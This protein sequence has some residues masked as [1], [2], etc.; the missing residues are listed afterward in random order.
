LLESIKACRQGYAEVQHIPNTGF[1]QGDGEIRKPVVAGSFYSGSAK[2]LRQQIEMCFKHPLGPGAPPAVP[3]AG[4]RQVRGLVSPHAGYIYS[5]PVASHGFFQLASDGKPEVV[6]ILGPNHRGVGAAAALSKESSWQTPLGAV[7][8]DSAAGNQ[9]IAASHW[10]QWD[11]IAHGWEHSIEVQ[12]PFLQY[13]YGAGFRLLPISIMRQDLE[14]SRD[15]GQ[16][17]ATALK[18]K[19]GIVV[20]STDFSHYEPQATASQKDHLALEAI[21][22]LSPERLEKVVDVNNISMCGVGPVMAMLFASKQLGADKARLLRY[23][24]SGDITGDYSQV[25]GYASVEVTA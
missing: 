21:L 10:L 14:V 25:V 17:I 11:D 22:S 8:I 2:E 5:G 3:K 13:I 9:I 12:L 7:E 15:L 18:N 19:D 24:T 1:A 4:P 16:A 20:A 23:A 6:V